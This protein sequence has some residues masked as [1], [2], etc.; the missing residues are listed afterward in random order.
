M[1]RAVLNLARNNA[2]CEQQQIETE[3]DGK[4]V[5]DVASQHGYQMESRQ[6]MGPAF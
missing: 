5:V 1:I 6:M 3:R 4:F 2:G